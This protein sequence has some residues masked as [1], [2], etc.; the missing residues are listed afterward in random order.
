MTEPSP[1]LT[2]KQARAFLNVHERT[3]YRLKHEPDFPRPVR[4]RGTVQYRRDELEKYILKRQ[5]AK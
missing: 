3:F 4:L 1:L 5:R 2:N